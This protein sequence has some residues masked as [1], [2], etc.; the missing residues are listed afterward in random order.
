MPGKYI[1]IGLINAMPEC[2]RDIGLPG[3][4]VLRAGNAVVVRRAKVA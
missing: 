1:L 4:G 2:P 3:M